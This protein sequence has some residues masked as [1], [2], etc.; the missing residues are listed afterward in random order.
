MAA[1]RRERTP[2]LVQ[3]WNRGAWAFCVVRESEGKTLAV[4]RQ[5]VVETTTWRQTLAHDRA[6]QH[7]GDGCFRGMQRQEGMACKP[8]SNCCFSN[9]ST[10][11]D[12]PA[13]RE[14]EYGIWQTL[15]WG[16]GWWSKNLAAGL[17]QAGLHRGEHMIVIG[18]TARACTPP[19]WRCSPRRHPDPL[20]QD[21]AAAECVYP[22][23]NAEVRFAF[24]EDQEQVDKLLEV[25]E[26]CPQLGPHLLRRSARPAQ[27]RR[28]GLAS[29][30]ELMAAGKVFTDQHPDFYPDEVD[31]GQ[32][33][34]W[35]PCSS[36]RAPRAT[37]RAWCTPT[38]PAQPRPPGRDNKL[39]EPTRCWPTCRPPGSAEHLLLRPV[40]GLRL[41]GEL[42]RVGRHGHHRPKE[43]NWGPT[44]TLHRRGC[45]KV[46]H[47]RDDPHGRRRRHQAQDVPPAWMW[48]GASAGPDGRQ[49][50][51]SGGPP[52]VRWATC[53]CM[54]RCA[55]TWAEPRARGLH[56]W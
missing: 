25:R 13:M 16:D 2:P 11:P 54:A 55:T 24:A 42:P 56:R 31:P 36:P 30:D 17:H 51:W 47:Q 32:P 21:A 1:I 5:I 41:C 43:G 49:A 14:K 15:T 28:P 39:G 29:L 45:L 10:R 12:A 33:T 46:A 3:G 8:F 7:P 38:T 35:R 37:P 27:L 52:A 9:A 4:L 18:P 40:A 23:N 34:T 20:Y 53:W 44:Y 19:C 6:Q 26:Q 22:I 50:R 48:P